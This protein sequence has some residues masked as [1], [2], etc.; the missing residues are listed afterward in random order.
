ML[1]PLE[2]ACLDSDSVKCTSTLEKFEP[3][4][5]GFLSSYVYCNQG[6]MH[7]IIKPG[8]RLVS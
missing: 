2:E 8:V 3:F 5:V 1:Q 6:N 7:V 4:K